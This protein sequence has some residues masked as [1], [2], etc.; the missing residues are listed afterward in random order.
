MHQCQLQT[1]SSLEGLG[2]APDEPGLVRFRSVITVW[3]LVALRQR[4]RAQAVSET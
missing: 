3:A 1:N 2:A 4:A